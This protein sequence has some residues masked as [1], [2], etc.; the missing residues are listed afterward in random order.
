MD[1]PSCISP[2]K[3]KTSRQ[4]DKRIPPLPVRIPAQLVT[5]L[6]FRAFCFDDDRRFPVVFTFFQWVN[7][8]GEWA[9]VVFV[10]EV[11]RHIVGG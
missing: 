8:A 4:T 5:N 2:I 11:G 3:L 10:D 1:H 7:R 6:I 9:V